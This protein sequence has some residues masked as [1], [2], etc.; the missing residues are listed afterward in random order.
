MLAS[1]AVPLSRY[2]IG[3]LE[4]VNDVGPDCSE[5]G[6]HNNLVSTV[7]LWMQLISG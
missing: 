7:T 2:V 4:A 3:K 1:M 6:N 5:L